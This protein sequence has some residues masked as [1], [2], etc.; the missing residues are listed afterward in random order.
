V[1]KGPEVRG[2]GDAAGQTAGH[3]ADGNWLK[4]PCLL[5][6]SMSL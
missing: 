1:E 2:R 4:G 3:P 5:P 6:A